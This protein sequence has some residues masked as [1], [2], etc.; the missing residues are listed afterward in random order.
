M[1]LAIF[2]LEPRISRMLAIISARVTFA[3]RT[4][5]STSAITDAARREASAFFCVRE[6]ISWLEAEVSSRELA[7]R[8]A[9][10]DMELLEDAI[11]SAAPA[12][13]VAQAVDFA[14]YSAKHTG[15]SLRQYDQHHDTDCE[16]QQ[17]QSR[18][19]PLCLDGLGFRSRTGLGEPFFFG[20]D[21]SSRC[22]T[23]LTNAW[24]DLLIERLQSNIELL[25]GQLL[26]ELTLAGVDR[27]IK[28]VSSSLKIFLRDVVGDRICRK[29]A[30][31]APV[32]PG[33]IP[34]GGSG[35]FP[36]AARPG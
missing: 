9:T 26:H 27:T 17:K 5:R 10:S 2:S 19:Q 32:K 30:A 18:H 20:L 36:A 14:R 33:R 13:C 1:I 11:C 16:G 28:G 31:K 25:R 7:C 6:L 34:D 12:T 15:D 22:F 8:V 29:I 23:Q 3:S 24:R 4:R 21:K 35:P